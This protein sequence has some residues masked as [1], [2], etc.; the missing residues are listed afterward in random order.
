MADIA[1]FLFNTD[2]ETA[3]AGVP[4]TKLLTGREIEQLRDSA[5]AAGVD[6]GAARE[7]QATEHRQSLALSVIA[8]RLEAIAQAQ[9]QAMN[10]IIEEATKLTL[11]IARKISPALSRHEPLFGI[12]AIIRDFLHQLIDEPHIVVRV[13]EN[14]IDDLKQ[15][16][17]D[18][19]AG[20]GFAG[21]VVLLPDPAMNGNDC[22]LEWADGGAVRNI[23]TILDDIETGV[24]RILQNPADLSGDLPGDGSDQSAAASR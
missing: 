13:P 8:N 2:F 12:E 3:G 7:N 15:R 1:K 10:H 14:L 6:E 19:A 18:I 16:I 4:D 20:C 9:D 22:R 23:N 17:D 24:A 5:F 21:R 11:M